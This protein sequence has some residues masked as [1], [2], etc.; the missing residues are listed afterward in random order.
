MTPPPPAALIVGMEVPPPAEDGDEV[1]LLVPRRR[2]ARTPNTNVCPV[3]LGLPGALPVLNARRVR[4]GVRARARRSAARSPRARS[5]TGRTTSI[6]TS[7]RATRSASTTSRSAATARSR[8]TRDGGGPK[9]SASAARTSRRT[10][11]SPSTTAGAKHSARGPQPLRH[12]AARD[13]QRSPTSPRPRRPAATSTSCAA[14]CVPGRL[15]RRH[16]EGATSAAS[17]T[18][19]CVYDGRRPRRRIVEVKNVNS[20]GGVERAI[21]FESRAPGPGVPRDGRDAGT[22]RAATRGWDDDEGRDGPP[23]RRRSRRTTTATSPSPTSRR[24]TSTA[25]LVEA[26]RRS[27]PELPRARR[28]RYVA[29]LGLSPY[30]AGVLDRRP[31]ARRLV[32]GGLAAAAR[33]R[34]GSREPG[35]RRGARGISRRP[36]RRRRDPVPAGAPGRARRPRRDAR[37]QLGTAKEVLQR[38]WET[39]EAPGSR[40]GAR[41]AWP[42]SPTRA[43]SAPPARRRSPRSRRRPT[44]V[45]AGND[46]GDRAG[47]SARAMKRL[48]GQG[49]PRG[50]PPDPRGRCSRRR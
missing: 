5:G 23:A 40:R 22:R 25:A 19:T 13:R 8:S 15:R 31:R 45:R 27:L 24:S 38:M 2:S 49:R 35:D 48:G 17:R 11:A 43:R 34:E 37:R 26:E 18:S 1:L 28:A 41:A 46:E 50:R 44:T 33:E 32:R 30:D 42:R 20:V 39:R 14:S 16:G 21:R 36:A 9:P 7:R 6:P 3:C 47:S 4:L 29:K 12:A 10:R